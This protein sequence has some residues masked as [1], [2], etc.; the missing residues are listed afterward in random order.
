MN[1][2][3]EAELFTAAGLVHQRGGPFPACAGQQVVAE[4]IEQGLTHFHSPCLWPQFQTST[5]LPS[6]TRKISILPMQSSVPSV[7]LIGDW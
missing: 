5:I 2:V 3:T 1:A 7:S 6:T 4:L